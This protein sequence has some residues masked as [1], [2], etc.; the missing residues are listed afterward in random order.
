MV[1][2]TRVPIACLETNTPLS[3]LVPAKFLVVRTIVLCLC[4]GKVLST[5]WVLLCCDRGRRR[6][7]LLTSRCRSVGPNRG[8]FLY[9]LVIWW[10]TLLGVLAP[11]MNFLVFVLTVCLIA[12]PGSS[13]AR[14]SI[15]GGLG[16]T[17]S[18]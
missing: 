16:S 9:M 14:T 11:D 1:D 7:K 6:R 4:L 5:V 3:T 8:L 12:P 18:R 17:W 13:D 15:R 2:E 10:T